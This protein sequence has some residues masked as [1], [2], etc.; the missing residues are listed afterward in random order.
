MH[1]LEAQARDFAI[2][3]HG[4]QKYGNLP[5]ASHLADVRRIVTENFGEDIN[6]NFK[7]EEVPERC[8][9][10]QARMTAWLHDVVEDTETTLEE[11]ERLFGKV[12]A[13]SVAMVTDEDGKNRK[14]RKLKTFF[15]L[16]RVGDDSNEYYVE[17][18]IPIIVK[19]ADRLANVES[20]VLNGC[21]DKLSMYRKEH[22]MF[23]IACCRKF[24]PITE[25]ESVL[26]RLDELLGTTKL[27][28]W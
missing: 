19:I 22:G 12:V 27:P 24:H 5:Y 14:E 1:H 21:D 15:K 7:G 13:Q 28:R 8:W 17:D 18:Y 10:L 11:V 3:R 20:C 2:E 9:R 4:S 25:M 6:K 26:D 23:A 16:A